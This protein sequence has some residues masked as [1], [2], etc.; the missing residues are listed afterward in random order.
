METNLPTPGSYIVLNTNNIKPIMWTV[1]G[2]YQSNDSFSKSPRSILSS[3]YLL[4]FIHPGD[5]ID[6]TRWAIMKPSWETTRA[7]NRMREH[8]FATISSLTDLLDETMQM[9]TLNPC[10]SQLFKNAWGYSLHGVSCLLVTYETDD[11][12]LVALHDILRNIH[13]ILAMPDDGQM[14]YQP[15][16]MSFIPIIFPRVGPGH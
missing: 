7:R 12:V 10:L 1:W 3:I 9:L 15:S 11:Q 13:E 6:T 14:T 2:W 4:Q 5:K 8:R 16:H